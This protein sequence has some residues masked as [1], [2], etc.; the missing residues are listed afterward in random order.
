MNA[1]KMVLLILAAG[2]LARMTGGVSPERAGGAGEPTVKPK[3]PIDNYQPGPDSLPQAGVPKGKTFS[4]SFESSKTYPGTR[5]E[6]SVYVPPQYKAD[7]PACVYVGFDGLGFDAATVFDNLISKGDMPVTIGVGISSG[8]VPPAN[9]KDDPRFNRSFEFDGLDDSL[10]RFV[11]EE[12][13]PEVQRHKTPDGLAIRLSADPND[14]CTGGGSTGG[15]A[16]FTCA[17]RR[18]DQFRRVFTAIGTFVCMRGG[19]RYPVLVR[20]TDPKPIRV[21]QQDGENDEWM[22]GPEV[23]DWWMGNQTLD[24]AL[25]FA[26]YEHLHA[27]GDGPHSGKHGEAVFPDAMRFLWKDWPKPVEAHPDRSQNLMLKWTIDPKSDWASVDDAGNTCSDLAVNP[28]GEVCFHDTAARATRRLDSPGKIVQEQ[29][30]P[31]ENAFGFGADGVAVTA[32]DPELSPTFLTVTGK[33]DVYATDAPAGKVWLVHPDKTKALL[34]QDLKQPTGIAISPG[35]LWLAVMERAS[36]TG[37]SYRVLADG[38]A[39]AKQ[40]FYW[41]HVPDDADDS[42]AGGACFDR[43]GRLYVATRMGVQ[44]FDRNGRSRAVLP[45]PGNA[46]ATSVCFG[47]EKFDTLFVVSGGRLFKRH[48]NAAGAPSFHPPI[49]LPPWG[50]G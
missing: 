27:W 10:A 36:H 29:K 4:F 2:V 37:Y 1:T 47:G 26:G 6:I 30:I 5:R 23:G 16:A 15:I 13:F 25:E 42:G 21:F 39:D 31:P 8:T 28:K 17:W 14:R 44:I 40:K 3:G 48:M 20:E 24:R 7:K 49:K 9:G 33:G 50:A 32:A 45:L 11:I 12:I 18:P 22:G 43:D 35:G 38:T 46:P 34:D 41:A 19:D